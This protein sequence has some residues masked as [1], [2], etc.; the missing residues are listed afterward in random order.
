VADCT[1]PAGAPDLLASYHIDELFPSFGATTPVGGL[2]YGLGM[3]VSTSSFNQ[4]LK[5]Q[6]ECGL[7]LTSVTEISLDGVSP[8]EPIT[9]DLLAALI[10]EFGV[11]APGTPLR[12]DVR[13]TLAPVVT[14]ATGPG[15]ELAELRIS[16]L[17]I[18]LVID[19]P[20][21]NTLVLGGFIDTVVGLDLAFDDLTGSLVFNLAPPS[22]GDVTAV[23]TTNTIGVNAG[24]LENFVLPGL[25]AELLPDLAGSLGEFP[26]PQFLGLNLE[27][28][29]ISRNGEFMSLFADLTP[30]P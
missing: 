10:P 22:A 24:L 8:P 18:D 30:A 23:I 1:P 3:G 7:L 28:V 9:T 26:L 19:D 29:E 13:P 5:A 16:H 4:L 25:V 14:G 21:V 11:F 15:G 12:I 27:G 17:A 20:E 2:P 6:I